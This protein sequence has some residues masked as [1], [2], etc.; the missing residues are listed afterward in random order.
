MVCAC[1]YIYMRV[2]LR[3]RVTQKRESGSKRAK[4][5]KRR[6]RVRRAEVNM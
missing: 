3:E 6:V 2:L 1:I 4:E 5:K